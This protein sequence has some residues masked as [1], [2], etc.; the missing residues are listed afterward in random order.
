[1]DFAFRVVA[2]AGMLALGLS[3]APVLIYLSVFLALG[4]VTQW[5]VARL[6]SRILN[7][8]TITTLTGD[9]LTTAVCGLV[10]QDPSASRKVFTNRLLITRQ[11]C[12]A[13]SKP[14]VSLGMWLALLGAYVGS[15]ALAPVVVLIYVV[16]RRMFSM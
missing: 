8:P 12:A 4:L 13:L 5:Q 7:D 2:V 3:M 6:H 10:V 14:P 16:L 9:A 1:M 11:V 15:C